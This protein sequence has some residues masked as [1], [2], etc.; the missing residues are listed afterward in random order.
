MK[1]IFC[2]AVICV[3]T[4]FTSCKVTPKKQE[5]RGQE[6]NPKLGACVF[7]TPQNSKTVNPSNLAISIHNG[8]GAFAKKM[9]VYGMEFIVMKD[10]PNSFL[11]EV[12]TTLQEIFPQDSSLN[13]VRQHKVLNNLIQYK[14]TIPV[15][16]GH[17]DAM[18][19]NVMEELYT[20]YENKCSVC[21][22]IMYNVPLQTMEVVEH[23]LHFITDIGLNYEYPEEWSFNTK[24]ATVFNVMQEAINKGFYDIDSYDDLKEDKEAYERVV[25]Q[26]FAYWLIS[27]YWNLQEEY[28]P[29]ENEWTIR[30]KD[31]LKNKLPSAY[32]LVENTV[33][34]IMKTPSKSILEKLQAN[35]K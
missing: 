28:G 33:G 25:I 13:L 8:S 19:E 31:E 21:D 14:A 29:N 7:A 18:P 17:H 1:K 20:K 24:D 11:E 12:G 35:Y 15:I 22:V 3:L 5:E 23:L 34:E 16:D 10:V 6:K 26:E 9:N 27:T 2:L 32:N 4:I 30:N